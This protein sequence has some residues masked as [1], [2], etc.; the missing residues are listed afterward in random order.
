MI[1]TGYGALSCSCK[2]KGYKVM[3]IVCEKNNHYIIRV[4]LS[5]T[6]ALVGYMGCKQT[7]VLHVPCK[8]THSCFHTYIKSVLLPLGDLHV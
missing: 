7:L 5:G 3:S 4:K 6:A 2:K 1:Q 8:V